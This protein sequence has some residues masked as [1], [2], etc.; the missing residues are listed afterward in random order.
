MTMRRSLSTG[1][2]LAA[3]LVWTACQVQ[4]DSPLPQ[5]AVPM[6]P[7]PQYKLW[8]SV[9]TQCAKI[10]RRFEDIHW[11][12]VPGVRSFST[13]V[14]TANGAYQQVNNRIILAE[15]VLNAGAVVRH[16][17]LHALLRQ[18]AHPV[19]YF[20]RRCSGVVTCN[21][22]CANAVDPSPPPG[23]A[24]AVTPADLVLDLALLPTTGE[25]QQSGGWY[26]AMVSVRNPQS[27][28]VRVTL[29]VLGSGETAIFGYADQCFRV[30]HTWPHYAMVLAPGE[31]R[32]GAFD[33]RWCGSGTGALRGRGSLGG[34][35]TVARQ[36]VVEP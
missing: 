16:E 2:R 12:V 3:V 19:D 6:T 5:T 21:G 35:S 27:T 22:T 9:T 1:R 23:A 4:V 34:D 26:V 10:V 18:P 32:F 24:T 13:E 17:M 8:W 30:T 28:P 36:F 11:Y 33:G 31:T 15:G 20:Q 14:G 25:L 7:L 29:P